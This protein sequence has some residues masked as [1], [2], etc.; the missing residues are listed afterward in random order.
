MRTLA[1]LA[2]AALALGPALAV[3]ADDAPAPAPFRPT[4]T[5]EDY[6]LF[7][8]RDTIY[9]LRRADYAPV[10]ARSEA[11]SLSEPVEVDAYTAEFRDEGEAGSVIAVTLRPGPKL[12]IYPKGVA[13]VPMAIRLPGNDTDISGTVFRR[14]DGE[15]F[16]PGL[17]R[18]RGGW[19]RPL[20]VTGPEGPVIS[21][22]G[23]L[24]ERMPPEQRLAAAAMWQ[25]DPAEFRTLVAGA[26]AGTAELAAGLAHELHGYPPTGDAPLVA[27]ASGPDVW[28]SLHP[29]ERAVISQLPPA[30]RAAFMQKIG[31]AR[32]EAAARALI[33][34]I[35]RAAT[36]YVQAGGR[37]D[38]LQTLQ[39]AVSRISRA[40]INADTGA[41]TFDGA[42]SP[43]AG[44]DGGATVAGRTGGGRDALNLI[45]A[46]AGR[47]DGRIHPVPGSPTGQ[48]VGGGGAGGTVMDLARNPG[49][50]AGAGALV[51]AGIGFLIGGPFGMFLGGMLGIPGGLAIGKLFGMGVEGA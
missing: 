34:E 27:G 24:I 40:T 19:R 15:I 13:G 3:A 12:R 37:P 17:P 14:S 5:F 21:D 39:A 28:Q 48:P 29:V 11:G 25:R 44:P 9:L 31:A 41:V 35:R 18:F 32:N 4:E 7:D 42:G 45:N 23:A 43:A 20:A 49:V 47:P 36:A 50:Q 10:R 46:R 38:A 6:V 1:L 16:G 51:G 26:Q 33:G 2:V 8:T 30:E 22:P